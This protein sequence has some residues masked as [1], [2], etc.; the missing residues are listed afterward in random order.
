[1]QTLDPVSLEITEIDARLENQGT[2]K[3]FILAHLDQKLRKNRAKIIIS[4]VFESQLTSS[5]AMNPGDYMRLLFPRQ[6]RTPKKSRAPPQK[7]Q[8]PHQ[9]ESN[10]LTALRQVCMELKGKY[11]LSSDISPSWS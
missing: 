1:M 5:S 9:D 6:S 4:F 2:L 3:L 8:P 10:F 7:K 11:R